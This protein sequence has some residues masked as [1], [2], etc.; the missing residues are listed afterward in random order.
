MTF[1][2]EVILGFVKVFS[3]SI[4]MI[5]WFEIKYVNFEISHYQFLYVETSLNAAADNVFIFIY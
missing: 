4:H 2:H 5:M 1:Y 3:A